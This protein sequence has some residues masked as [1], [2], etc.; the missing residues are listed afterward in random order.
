MRTIVPQAIVRYGF[1]LKKKR[2]LDILVLLIWKKLN[3]S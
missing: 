2:I 3:V 1:D